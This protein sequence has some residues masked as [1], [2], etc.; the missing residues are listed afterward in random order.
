MQWH[1]VTAESAVQAEACMHAP[2]DQQRRT[3]SVVSARGR[4]FWKGT[5][6]SVSQVPGCSITTH[7][8]CRRRANSRLM[9]LLSWFCALLLALRACAPRSGPVQCGV[10][11]R[12]AGYALAALRACTQRLGWCM[13][14]WLGQRLCSFTLH[15]CA[16][17]LSRQRI[18]DACS[19]C[20]YIALLSHGSYALRGHM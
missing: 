7:T 13:D 4:A 11:C 16:Q 18:I 9:H 2:H 15:V 1:L 19:L 8:L 14:E 10:I 17:R 12:T 3:L 6:R 5:E 20:A